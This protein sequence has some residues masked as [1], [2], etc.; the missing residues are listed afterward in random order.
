MEEEV[1]YK[2]IIE[3]VFEPRRLL[4]A[5]QQVRSNA[6]AA[7]MDQMTVSAFECRESEDYYF[8]NRLYRSTTS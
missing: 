7:G 1:R 5:W 8:S 2:Q 4:A 3:K 6:G